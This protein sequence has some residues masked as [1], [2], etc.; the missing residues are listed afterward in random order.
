MLGGY[1]LGG[2]GIW[3]QKDIN[4]PAHTTVTLKF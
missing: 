3:Y 4:L 2:P 1:G